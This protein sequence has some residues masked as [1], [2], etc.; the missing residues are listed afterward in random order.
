[1]KR[2][3][4]AEIVEVESGSL[5]EELG[6][7]V[8]DSILKINK[9]NVEDLI[10]FQLEWAGEEILLEIK[11][12]NGKRELYQIE[13]EY[14]EPL[15]AHF[16]E[17]I[18]NGIKTC[19]N[20][21]VFCFVDQMPPGMRP[22]LYIKDDDY[23]L[24][25]L[26]GSYITLTNLTKSDIERI[27]R[28]HLSPLYVSV[29]TTDP[30]LRTS[31]M[32][33]PRAGQVLLIMEELSKAGI[34]FHT[35]IVACPGINDGT[36]LEKTY[37]EL[38]KIRGVISLAVVPV[39]LTGYR[40][41]LPKLRIYGQEEARRLVEWAEEKQAL[42][43]S[44]RGSRFIWPSDE[45]Y[46]L[47]DLAVPSFAAYEDFPQLEN[48]VGMVRLLWDE[49][50]SLTLPAELKLRREVVFVTGM[51]GLKVMQP[52]VARLKQ[53]SGLKIALVSVPNLFFGSTVTVTGLLTGSC[54][55]EGL[56][57]LPKGSIVFIPEA[58]V[59]SGN[60]K[61]LDDVTPAEVGEKLELQM[62][63][64]PVKAE[65]IWEKILDLAD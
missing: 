60:G 50:A 23:R 13:K 49:F 59:Q 39:G 62:I 53:I 7:A 32:K 18:F 61:F 41:D 12:K 56:K 16:Q 6:L 10:G 65:K 46:L 30:Q 52:I 54:L 2:V 48:G 11:K 25:F 44:K 1:M 64:V 24:S 4:G 37:Q 19:H 29:H 38:S 3:R 57:D 22:S 42:E 33:N 21:C 26:Q 31:L 34:E 51:S 15:G 43:L 63:T 36:A 40:S 47:A 5:A 8:G 35:Q 9:K 20:K 45:F 27:K 28:E 17:A 58:M 55:L 14:D